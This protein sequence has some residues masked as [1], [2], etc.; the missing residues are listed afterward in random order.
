MAFIVIS[1]YW[2]T[3]NDE[4]YRRASERDKFILEFSSE[5]GGSHLGHSKNYN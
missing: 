4:Q 5:H 2:E 3:G 1:R